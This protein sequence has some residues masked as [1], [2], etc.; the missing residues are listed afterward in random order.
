[1]AFSGPTIVQ[2]KAT[3][4]TITPVGTVTLDAPLTPGNSLLV[5][6]T[7]STSIDKYF[8]VYA[9]G[10]TFATD[11]SGTPLRTTQSGRSVDFFFAE[12]TT[13]VS[14]I[15]IN[16]YA[17]AGHV[18]SANAVFHAC[19]IELT[20]CQLSAF[21]GTQNASSVTSF[22]VADS[23]QLDAVPQSFILGAASFNAS[24][25]T[26]TAA[27]GFT[28]LASSST[29]W[30]FGVE[31]K[32]SEAGETD[33]QAPFG[34]TTARLGPGQIVALTSTAS[35]APYSPF[36]SAAFEPPQFSVGARF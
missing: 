2:A 28:L 27:T 25:G 21:S 10:M 26:V 5:V 17:D 34:L 12:V 29:T 9:S 15:D 22:P 30:F 4:F 24:G 31:Y 36:R 19:V 33:Q 20:S 3:L 14:E 7:E 18:S 35:A 23:G 8:S 32:Q 16:V 1:M 11:I 6:V 13:A